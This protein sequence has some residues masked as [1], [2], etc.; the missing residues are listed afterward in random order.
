MN[1][2]IKKIWLIIVRNLSI[3]LKL[4]IIDQFSKWWFISSLRYRDGMT[5]EVTSFLDMVYT[6]NYGISFGL[7]RDYYQYSNSLFIVINTII[8]AYLWYVLLHSKT[9]SSFV[10]YSFVIGGAIGNLIDR[11]I[12]GA[13]FDFIYFH[14]KDI[15]FPVFNLADSF[16]SLGVLFLIHDYYKLKKTVEV[17]K[18]LEYNRSLI[19]SGAEK[20]R[21]AYF[22]KTNID[23]K[24]D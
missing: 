23:L 6:W 14:Y 17:E 8:T 4:V 19:E 18:E 10:G 24:G 3:V 9:M 13:V 20:I 5:L 22:E 1:V 16:I 15:G 7:L 21:K 2:A 11:F 12:N